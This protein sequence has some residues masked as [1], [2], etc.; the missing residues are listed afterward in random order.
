VKAVRRDRTATALL[1]AA[2]KRRT[3]RKR[4]SDGL[5]GDSPF[6]APGVYSFNR[7]DLDRIAA[8]ARERERPKTEH[9]GSFLEQEFA[10]A[11]EDLQ[12]PS[13]AIYW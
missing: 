6:Q 8:P 13:G 2:A 5:H 9:H 1:K 4:R 3:M 11:A 12:A 10:E 7:L